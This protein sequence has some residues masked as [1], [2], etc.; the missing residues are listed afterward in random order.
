VGASVLGLAS[1]M[2]ARQILAVNLI[3]D[4]LP[5]LA[6]A[7]QQPEHRN[8]AGLA[9]E[10]TAALDAP[11]RDDVLRRGIATAAPTLAAYLL[12]LRSGAAPQARTIGFASIVATQ[13]A[14]TLELGRTDGGVSG[15]V[16]GAVA[17]SAALLVA[18]LTAPPLRAFLGLVMPGPAGWLLIGAT[19]PVAVAL[20]RLLWPTGRPAPRALVAAP[21]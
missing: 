9:R 2:T 17:G 13:L 7:L 16:L 21:A 14:Q 11:L 10:G 6:V 20:S 15:W 19:A 4:A 18:A 3:T 12:A 1:A 5:A 8:L